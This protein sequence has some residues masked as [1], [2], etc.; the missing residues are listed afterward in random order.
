MT[1]GQYTPPKKSKAWLWITLTLVF[2]LIAGGVAFTGFVTPGF[3]KAKA[4]TTSRATPEQLSQS[5]V[6]GVGEGRLSSLW[7]PIRSKRSYTSEQVMAVSD[8]AQ[9]S[10]PAYQRAPQEY[11]AALT[12]GG[13]TVGIAM[14]P[15]EGGWCVR[16]AKIGGEPEPLPGIETKP[17]PRS[18]VKTGEEAGNKFVDAINARDIPAALSVLCE[19]V[20]DTTRDG[21][22]QI[23]HGEGRYTVDTADVLTTAKQTILHLTGD[24]DGVRNP[25][26]IETEDDAE[27]G[28]CVASFSPDSD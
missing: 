22:Q 10:T 19:K 12:T 5:F 16:D 24:V 13:Q 25:G 9:L 4:D 2:V 26:R 23:I 1:Y 15:G 8:G 20:P 3:F 27:G 18:G 11:S 7:C 17:S 21:V 28:P 14:I 6:N